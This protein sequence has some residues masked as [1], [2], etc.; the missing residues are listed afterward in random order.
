MPLAHL[1]AVKGRGTPDG[2]CLPFKA[3]VC[4]FS[5]HMLAQCP[6]SAAKQ[7]HFGWLRQVEN[8]KEHAFSVLKE[9]EILKSLS[10]FK[11]CYKNTSSLLSKTIWLV[12]GEKEL[13]QPRFR[14]CVSQFDSSNETAFKRCAKLAVEAFSDSQRPSGRI[15]DT[16]KSDG[17]L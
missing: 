7:T 6:I 9:I 11:Y 3:F 13:M 4:G 17:L 8:P 1:W 10:S 12:R 5:H 14:R 15:L 16:I 2:C